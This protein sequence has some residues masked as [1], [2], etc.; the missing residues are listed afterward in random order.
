[1]T[2]TSPSSPPRPISPCGQKLVT[3][4]SQRVSVLMRRA[5][6]NI[7]GSAAVVA[8]TVFFPMASTGATLL[9]FG[10]SLALMMIGF[11]NLTRAGDMRRDTYR[12]HS[13]TP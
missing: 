8:Y 6:L 3:M 4:P 11:K 1:M 7:V 9:L 13:C 5:A 12:G 10:C 2:K